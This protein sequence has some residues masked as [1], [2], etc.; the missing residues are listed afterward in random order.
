MAQPPYPT[1]VRM[2]L[3]G[4][5][6]VF[7]GP[8]T[9]EESSWRL[10]KAAGL[11]KLLALAPDHRL[12]REQFTE[13]LWPGQGRRMASNSFRQALYIARRT[14][15]P[16][17]AVASR[18]LDYREEHLTLCPHHPLWVDVEA[19]EEAASTAR[20]EKE[21]AAYRAAIDLY[22]GDLLL[23]DRYEEWAEERRSELRS[24]FLSLL[25]EL[26]SLCEGRGEYEAAV[27]ALARTVA[28]EPAHE[29]AHLG[30]MRLYARSGRPVEAL[31]QYERLE[32]ILT[33]VLGTHPGTE[34]RRL[35]DDIAAGRFPPDGAGDPAVEN[36][37][38]KTA[39]TPRHHNLPAARTSFVGRRHEML[40]V[41]RA[42]AMTRLLTLTGA[43][44]SGKTRL[45][46]EVGK[47][48]LGA[49]PDGVWLVELAGLSEGTLVP[50]AVAGVLG[51]Q[52]RAGQSLTDTIGEVLRW[53]R[54]LLVL[55][56]CEHL[57]EAAASLVDALLDSCQELRI[58][59]TSRE[60]LGVAGE[61]RWTVP[62][63]S[64]PGPGSPS[65][66]EDLEGYESARLF[67]ER[68][69]ERRPG[70]ALHSGNAVAVAEICRK[71]DGIPLAIELAAARTG[72]LAVE[73]I[74]GRLA[75]SLEL[76]TDGGRTR[77]P[78]Q[79]TLRGALDWSYELLGEEE[80]KLFRR[81]SVFAGGWTL[82]AAEVVGAGND[83]EESAVIELLSQLVDKSLVR[84]ELT[85]EALRYGFL[86]PVR[87]YAREK[88]GQSGEAEVV[89]RKHAAFFLALAEEAEPRLRGPQD[90]E[91]LER[92][93]EEHDNMRAAL[94]WVLERG[95]FELGLMLAGALGM[96]WYAHG[97]LGE[98]RRWLEE[99]LVK[100]TRASLEA[101]IRALEALFWLAVEQWD[102]DRAEAVS[103]GGDGAER[104]SRDRE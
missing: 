38:E 23:A 22:A 93:E 74:S 75:D 97:H 85:G 55:D 31:R 13:A 10:K 39:W 78:R 101:R 46:L 71:L 102:F 72:A 69:S 84:I 3:L 98:G 40:E 34:T 73:E 47:D 17:A 62:A 32:E 64:V 27:E 53:K 19:F 42:L 36:G 80:R 30:L 88:L 60:A 91:W 70:F 1:A 58:L 28:N 18:L 7:V 6:R 92:L 56:N 100:D 87:Q 68:A 94:L 95:E 43:G 26:A 16:D 79:R 48:L 82:A 12:H 45:A 5:F 2:R 33:R 99:T 103:P 67:A 37:P 35:R 54:M 63:L 81:L 25:V 14:L 20:K 83:L 65:A 29:R 50:P 86:E 59:A 44:G 15:D 24:T 49:Y 96:F 4:T 89:R 90:R 61:I 57:V 76:L 66:V 51:V 41:K 21:P 9:I 8:R 52:E 11:V 77:S 104:R